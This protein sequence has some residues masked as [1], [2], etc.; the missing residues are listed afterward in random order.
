[1][2]KIAL[3]PGSFDPLT[4]G[5]VDII[6]RGSK[7]FDEI[8][9]GIFTNPTK[10]SWFSPEEK[11]TL[12]KEALRHLPNVTVILQKQELT[13]KSAKKLHAQFLLRGIRSVKDLEYER[14]IYSM[15]R[16]LDETIESIFLLTSPEYAF[17]SSSLLKEVLY[18]KGDI[19][20]YV[21][22]NIGQ[23]LKKKVLQ[24]EN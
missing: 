17:V 4:L 16:H 19:Y 6:E 1:M 10:T 5:H 8:I 20:A 23:A 14:D 13:V 7:L 2:K 12:T 15:N 11:L 24:N 22:K 9:V 3:F 18:F 21:P